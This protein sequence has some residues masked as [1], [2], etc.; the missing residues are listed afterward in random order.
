[1]E[2]PEQVIRC[3]AALPEIAHQ[4]SLGDTVTLLAEDY[5]T[6]AVYIGH[7]IVVAEASRQIH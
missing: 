3:H 7:G 1:M 4:V 6:T 5:I 2:T